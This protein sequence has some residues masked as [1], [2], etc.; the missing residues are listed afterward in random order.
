MQSLYFSLIEKKEAQTRLLY[1]IVYSIFVRR[2]EIRF[3]YYAHTTIRR[4]HRKLKVMWSNVPCLPGKAGNIVVRK[5]HYHKRS[6]SILPSLSHLFQSSDITTYS[7]HR[8]KW[9]LRS[10]IPK[11]A[12]RLLSSQ[13]FAGREPRGPRDCLLLHTRS[14]ISRR[15]PQRY[16]TNSL[17]SYQSDPFFVSEKFLDRTGLALDSLVFDI[18]Q[19]RHC[20]AIVMLCSLV[21]L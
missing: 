13:P 10:W 6:I 4:R 20:H 19:G 21:T 16:L 3:E 12:G 7:C 17:H 2:P 8:E 15:P 1:H 18:C 14:G 11:L 5:G 9:R